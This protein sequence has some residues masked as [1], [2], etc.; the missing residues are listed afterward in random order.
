MGRVQ[1]TVRSDRGLYSVAVVSAL[2]FAAHL[3]E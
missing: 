3:A 1:L 2:M